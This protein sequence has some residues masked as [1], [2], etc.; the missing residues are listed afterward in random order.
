[1]WYKKKSFGYIYLFI[2]LFIYCLKRERAVLKKML[3]LTKNCFML[4]RYTSNSFK[5]FQRYFSIK[6]LVLKSVCCKM[7]WLRYQRVIISKHQQE[8][9]VREIT[10]LTRTPGYTKGGITCVGG[11]SIFCRP[12]TS[13]VSPV[14]E[15]W[16]QN[17]PLLKS[18]CQVRSNYWYEKCQTTY[19]SMKV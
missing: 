14:S 4:I 15:S 7:K 9:Q 8:I 13:A 19:G 18:V 17:Y 1:M 2:H 5:T 3:W 6:S 11:L 16:M 12:V 10:G